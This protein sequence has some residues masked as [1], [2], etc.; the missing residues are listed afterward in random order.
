M[1]IF[2]PSPLKE[3]CPDLA[4]CGSRLEP[5]EQ[6]NVFRFRQNPTSHFPVFLPTSALRY[7]VQQN[8][9]LPRLCTGPAACSTAQTTPWPLCHIL[10]DSDTGLMFFPISLKPTRRCKIPHL[11]LLSPL[12]GN[13][14]PGQLQ[15]GPWCLESLSQEDPL[16]CHSFICKVYCSNSLCHFS[17]GQDLTGG[18]W[19][20]RSLRSQ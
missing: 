11:P 2:L 7:T 3:T 5:S 17:I 1:K 13:V 9:G 4:C 14:K 18:H 10:L 19:I 8:L 20:L 6:R 16:L 15:V 12:V